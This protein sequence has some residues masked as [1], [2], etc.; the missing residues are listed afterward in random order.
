M[1]GR[2]TYTK[3][4]IDQG[5][6][7]IDHQ[8][9]AYKK[10]VRAG[11]ADP[12]VKSALQAFEAPFFNNM[13]LVLD[14]YHVHRL[15]GADYEGKDG[16]AL[17]EVRIEL[18]VPDEHF[19]NCSLIVRSA[20]RAPWRADRISAMWAAERAGCSSRS[21]T[22]SSIS[23]AWPRALPWSERGR[24]LSPASPCCR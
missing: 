24:S 12:N 9:G 11:S 18:R 5:K 2:K 6:A 10:L 23:S 14:R 3:E 13:T 19:C 1:L 8:V 7:A 15:P 20:M 17:N 16:N 22:A 4:E 21:L